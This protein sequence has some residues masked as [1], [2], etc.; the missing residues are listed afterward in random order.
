LLGYPVAH[1]LSPQIHNHA[2]RH[3]DIPY[4]Y[5]PLPVHKSALH[6]VI[7]TIRECSFAG[8]NVTIPHKASVVHYCDELSELS[9][10]TGTVNTL[11]FKDNRLCGTTTDPQGFFRALAWMGHKLEN[12]NVVILGNG[13]TSR[14]LGIALTLDKNIRSLSI[15]GRNAERV[16]A[17]ASEISSITNFRV[18]HCSVSDSQTLKSIMDNCDLLVNCTSAG[19]H[20]NT[21]QTPL[22]ATYFH[23]G[24]TVFDVIY[25]PAE[26]RFLAEA[27][28]AG[29]KTQ[30]GLRMLLYQGLSSFKLWTGIDVPEEIYDLGALSKMI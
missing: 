21:Q 26:T 9:R 24:M 4:A 15:A 17:L 27:R 14:T 30:N 23:K 6:S 13:G 20:P 7:H 22:P 28:Q 8:A 1:S 19:M 16:E 5:I 29:C 2:F 18:G 25:N 11:Y 12:S 10:H 3:L